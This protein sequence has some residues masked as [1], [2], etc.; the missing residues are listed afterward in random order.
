MC[1]F[2]IEDACLNLLKIEQL[3]KKSR[4]KCSCQG[5]ALPMPRRDLARAKECHSPAKVHA[6]V[7]AVPAHR[8]VP[9]SYLCSHSKDGTLC[10]W[11]CNTGKCGN[12]FKTGAEIG[13]MI[14]EGPWLFVGSPSVIKAMNSQMGADL[15]LSE[16]FGQIHSLKVGNDLLFAGTQV[17]DLETLQCIKVLT[18]HT[19]AVTSVIGFNQCLLSCSLDQTIKVW[20]HNESKGNL[21]AIYTKYVDHGLRLLH[22]V[23]DGDGRAV[24]MCSYND[25]TMRLYDLPSMFFTGDGALARLRWRKLMLLKPSYENCSSLAM[26]CDCRFAVSKDQKQDADVDDDF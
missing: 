23:R 11:D 15:I 3:D 8:K 9:C 20:F 26:E 7:H 12:V 14:S 1:G 22:G 17:W 6:K 10:I 13:C 4:I 21:E 19:D 2:L 24:L 5:I 16:T 18:E 25:K